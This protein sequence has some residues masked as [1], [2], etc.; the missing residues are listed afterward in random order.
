[1]GRRADSVIRALTRN[2]RSV[3]LRPYTTSNGGYD[4]STGSISTP[5]AS[6]SAD[7]SRK[8][9]IMDQLFN[10]PTRDHGESFLPDTLIEGIDK[11]AFMDA[12]GVDPKIQDRVIDG[13][14]D[15]GVM[16]V[17]TIADKD[18]SILHTLAL[19]V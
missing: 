4:P 1:M 13:S 10:K 19:K 11:W 9:L 14:T 8:I 3:T 7:V 2:G 16:R 12:N 17:W 6:G 18:G 5:G 15:Y